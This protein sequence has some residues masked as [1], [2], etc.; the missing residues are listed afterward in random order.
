MAS[1]ADFTPE[2]WSKIEFAPLNTALVI[3][4]ASPSG[5]IGMVQ[6]LFAAVSSVVDVEKDSAASQILKDVAA[7]IKARN[8]K[9]EMPRF[10]S[11]EEGR[12]HVAGQLREAIALLDAKADA[13]APAIKQWLYGVAQKS[14]QAAKEGGFLGIGGTAVSPEESA[15]LAELATMLGVTPTL[16]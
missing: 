1:K 12:A 16:S 9:P 5:P 10:S 8:E 4:L 3:A 15:A 13:D 6:E 7:D 14:A 2:E 11:V